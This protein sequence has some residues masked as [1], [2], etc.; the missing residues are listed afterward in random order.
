MVLSSNDKH[1]SEVVR[2]RKC[3]WSVEAQAGSFGKG[4]TVAHKLEYDLNKLSGVQTGYSEKGSGSSQAICSVV[5]CRRTIRDSGFQFRVSADSGG[6]SGVS[7]IGTSSA[8]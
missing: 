4:S 7:R 3:G 2:L 8:D 5:A 1:S 6:I